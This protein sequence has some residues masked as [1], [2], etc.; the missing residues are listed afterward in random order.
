L[1]GGG[2]LAYSLEGFQEREPMLASRTVE[3]GG[4]RRILKGTS[5]TFERVV[6][7]SLLG[8]TEVLGVVGVEICVAEVA[9]HEFDPE[10]GVEVILMLSA[11]Q[12]REFFGSMS[13]VKARRNVTHF[14]RPDAYG[15]EL[16]H[17]RRLTARG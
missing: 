6:V 9:E 13:T 1:L 11:F 10:D 15:T 12:L 16:M 8:K 2:T 17:G 7:R 4:G 5:D 14:E 3:I